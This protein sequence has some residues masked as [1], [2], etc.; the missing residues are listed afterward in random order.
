MSC[1]VNAFVPDAPIIDMSLSY[2]FG[3]ANFE[4]S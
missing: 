2:S 4:A 3:M 1:D